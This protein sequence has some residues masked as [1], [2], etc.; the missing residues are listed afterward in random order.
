MKTKWKVVIGLVGSVVAA[1]GVL[2]SVRWSRSAQVTVQTATVVRGDLTSIV[3]ASGEI[4][5]RTYTNL[6]A[7][8]QGRITDLLVKEGDHV[9][10]GEVVARIES[11]QATADVQAQRASVASA[12]A[13]STASEAGIKVLDDS[14]R[15]QQATIDRT[16]SDLE[17]ARITFDRYDQLFKGGVAP[18]Q[19]FDQRKAAYDSQVA[20][21]REAELRLEQLKSQR[22]QTLAQITSS[23]RRVAQMQAGLT[24]VSDILAKHD[25]VAPLDGIV[26]NLPVQVG[27][28]VV[29]GIQNSA[30]SSVMTVADMSLITAEVKVDETD[31]VNLQIGQKANVTIDAIPDRTFSGHVS[32]I[33]NTAILRST[34]QV[35]SNSATS[36]TEAKDFKVVIALDNPP[37]EVRPGL[38]C[39]AKIVTATRKDV[40]AIPIQALTVRQ[41]GDL[42][43]AAAPK[44]KQKDNGQA[45]INLA[46]EKQR[47][48][49]I[50]G[51]FVIANQKAEFHKVETGITGSTDIEVLSGVQ[52][53][54][55]IV[56]G[57]YQAIRTMRPGSRIKI[58]N[59]NV[60][61]GAGG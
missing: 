54:D 38:S 49:E 47:R 5:P 11:I 19:D 1:G 3:T 50:T 4:K 17:L 53:G 21:L 2:A 58:D 15:T 30:A 31:I 33:G 28:T 52:P 40:L 51:V 37:Q 61:V 18:R 24:R 12:E 29:P 56:I 6:G 35:A 23:Q 60:V 9:R 39:T 27:E 13:D 55:Q 20:A 16:K 43:D 32:E 10:R 46:A 22:A 25:V 7:N 45:P 44:Q 42:E 26:T 41:K 14:I 57:S 59:R 8:A 34:G 36:S 48:E